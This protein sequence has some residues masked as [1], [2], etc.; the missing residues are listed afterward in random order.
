VDEPTLSI[1]QKGVRIK[2]TGDLRIQHRGGALR[3]VIERTEQVA[4]TLRDRAIVLTGWVD[5]REIYPY[6]PPKTS[7]K[8]LRYS[9]R[10]EADGR[11][12]SG[13][14]DKQ[15]VWL[16]PA[17]LERYDPQR[18]RKTRDLPIP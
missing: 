18:C 12:L 6:G 8:R 16:V 15:A 10:L 13:T 11:G 14:R 9:L 7:H 2:G 17:T 5:E 3:P 4:G 1:V